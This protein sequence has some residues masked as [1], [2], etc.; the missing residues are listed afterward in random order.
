MINKRPLFPTAFRDVNSG[1]T[2]ERE[3][4]ED[5]FHFTSS[6]YRF[7]DCRDLCLRGHCCTIEKYS[8]SFIESLSLAMSR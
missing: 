1:S 6:L 3:H 2:A 7:F 4:K 8:V 5:R